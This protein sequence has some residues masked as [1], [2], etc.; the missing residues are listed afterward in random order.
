MVLKAIFDQARIL[1]RIIVPYLG[2]DQ[3][4]SRNTG[5]PVEEVTTRVPGK[6]DRV[7]RRFELPVGSAE[8]ARD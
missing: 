5:K 8:R 1:G 7:S 3:K 4:S 2:P 6:E